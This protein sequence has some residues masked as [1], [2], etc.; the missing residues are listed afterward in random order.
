MSRLNVTSK[1]INFTSIHYT[2]SLLHIELDNDID[3]VSRMYYACYHSMKAVLSSLGQEN[4]Q[5]EVK[6]RKR[7]RKTSI[8]INIDDSLSHAD[9]RNAFMIIYYRI[10]KLQHKHKI[11]GLLEKLDD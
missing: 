7:F 9:L 1:W 10:S 8:N 2:N 11:K 3:A 5:G 6:Y 4:I